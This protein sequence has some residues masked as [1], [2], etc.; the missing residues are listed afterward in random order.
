[1]P[2]TALIL[3]ASG[4]FGRHA[5][6]AFEAAGW[7]AKPFTRGG[8]LTAAAMGTDVIVNAWNPPYSQWTTTVPGLTASVIAAAKASGATV[9]I[10][11]N[12]YVF[13]PDM[14]GVIGPRVAHRAENPLGQVRRAL[15]AAYAAS[16]VR[17]ILLRAGDFLDTEASGNWFDS[18]MAKPVAKGRLSY[19]G[20]TDIPHAWAYLPDLARAAVALAERRAELPVF[21]DL[22]FEGYTL[23]GQE[24]AAAC[25]AALG[26]EIRVQPM[27]WLP[28][29]LARPFWPE[30]KHLIEMRYLWDT[31]HQLDGSDL[32]RLIPDLRLTPPVD[33][34]RQ[35]LAPVAGKLDIDP[36][37]AVA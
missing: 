13:G 17:T 12:V 35:A 34:L 18:V 33:A 15:E 6:Q 5:R 23:S 19:P 1:M 9:I 21:A 8:D 2:G 7:Q 37:K 29:R 4:R 11:G 24:L 10:P 30:A 26:R 25:A 27:N 32:M 22:A 28:I 31:P 20:R 36:D 14:P 3:G 16:G